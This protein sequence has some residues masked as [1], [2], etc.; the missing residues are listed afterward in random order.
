M[1]MYKDILQILTCG[2]K[3]LF[4]EASC[5]KIGG[6]ALSAFTVLCETRDGIERFLSKLTSDKGSDASDDEGQTLETRILRRHGLDYNAAKE[7]LYRGLE[8]SMWKMFR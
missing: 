4:A 8:D 7:E 6:K 2:I 3:E 5:R 1:E